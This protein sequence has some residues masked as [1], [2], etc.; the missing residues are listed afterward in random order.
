VTDLHDVPLGSP[1][2]GWRPGDVTT[3][4][5]LGRQAVAFGDSVD[6]I[7]ALADVELTDGVIEIDVALSGERAFHGLVWRIRDE[8]NQNYECFYVRPH[9]VGNDDS[10]QYNPVFN[11]V[12]S[13]QLYH[14]PGFWAAVTFP[15][16]A[17]FT[18]RV[19]FAGSRAE[20]FVVDMAAPALEVAELKMPVVPGRIGMLI[21]GPGLFVA[22]FAYADAPAPFRGTGLPPPA[23]PGDAGATDA[24]L[25]GGPVAFVRS[26]L[27]SDAFAEP[28]DPPT[29]L[30][31]GALDDRTWTRLAAEP[32][33]LVN[34]AQVQGIVGDRNTAWARTTISSERARVV[35][36][37]LGFSDRVVVYLNG[38]ALYRG[39]DTYRS[40]DYRFLGSI[41]WYDTIYLPLEAGANDLAIAVSESFGGWGI[42][43]HFGPP[44][45]LEGLVL[46][47]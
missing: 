47:G 23:D 18:V 36:M 35:P 5:H 3:V 31:A 22:R 9:Q 38:T 41:G 28:D 44:D 4:Q 30:A 10:V 13:W 29:H 32:T 24:A 20:V 17:W 43:A 25:G 1:A 2:W 8:A 7:A 40:R 45:S 46:D 26:W 6:L 39:D 16:G 15:I 21:G 12:A 11:D 19:V 37:H 34:L 33:G 27:V 14:V 42:Q